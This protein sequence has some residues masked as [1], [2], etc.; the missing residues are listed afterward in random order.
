VESGKEGNP[1]DKG[2]QL[3]SDD[4]LKARLLRARSSLLQLQ[5]EI[6]YNDISGFYT[7]VFNPRLVLDRTPPRE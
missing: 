7:A 4:G 1:F 3:L 2:G 5:L 6:G